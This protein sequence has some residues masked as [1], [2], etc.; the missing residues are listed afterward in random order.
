M[1]QLSVLR[2]RVRNNV[3][4]RTDKDSIVDTLI[5][6]VVSDLG[7]RFRW[8]DL[9]VADA[10]TT[11]SADGYTITLPTTVRIVDRITIKNAGGSYYTMY[12]TD[13]LTQRDIDAG[14]VVPTS[15]ATPGN[16]YIMGRVIHFDKLADA[17]YTCYIDGWIYTVD[18]TDDTDTPSIVGIDELIVAMA[19][20]RLYLHLKQSQE[21]QEWM[22]L[23]E[24]I[25]SSYM[26]ETIGKPIG[27]L[28]PA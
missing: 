18:M 9:M 17:D 6:N 21:A 24:M 25:S 1:A 10:T 27:S 22:G 28:E 20:S 2:S 12:L 4:G 15:T 13:R 23:A 11:L 26:D 7:R 19:T 5:N 16:C 3:G 8:N 14:K